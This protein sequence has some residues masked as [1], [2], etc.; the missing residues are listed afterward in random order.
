MNI[1]AHIALCVLIGVILAL[2][3]VVAIPVLLGVVA[4]VIWVFVQY[5][6]NL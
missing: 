1:V 3:L 2:I 5:G 6:W 4:Q